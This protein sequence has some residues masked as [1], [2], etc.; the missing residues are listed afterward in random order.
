FGDAGGRG[1][2]LGVKAFDV[3][4]GEGLK[5]FLKRR[6]LD[7]H[8]APGAQVLK[9]DTLTVSSADT[10]PRPSPHR[11]RVGISGGQ[12]RRLGKG[13]HAHLVLPPLNCLRSMNAL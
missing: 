2:S 10:A 6:L 12:L 3:R 4:L 11:G 7:E 13:E 9:M 1:V 5:E 8:A